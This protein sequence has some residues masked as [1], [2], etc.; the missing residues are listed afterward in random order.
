MKYKWLRN[1]RW[2]WFHKKLYWVARFIEKHKL[3][4]VDLNKQLL[5]IWKRK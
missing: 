5:E 1:L 3:Y 4:P 2:W